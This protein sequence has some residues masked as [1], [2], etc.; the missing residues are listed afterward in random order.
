MLSYF[1]FWGVSLIVLFHVVMSPNMSDSVC[2][3]HFQKE[4]VANE[5]FF[6]C[7]R[8]FLAL[9]KG[10]FKIFLLSENSEGESHVEWANDND[11]FT[12]PLD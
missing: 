6:C 10:F 3:S 8:A 12:L 4:W 5:D 11:G 1:F 2:F 9:L 7:R